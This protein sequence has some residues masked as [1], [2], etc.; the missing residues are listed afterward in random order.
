MRYTQ[1]SLPFSG[2]KEFPK[3]AEKTRYAHSTEHR[4]ELEHTAKVAVSQ[5]ACD[6]SQLSAKHTITFQKL[7]TFQ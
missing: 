4:E 3:I 7:T 5:L 6:S 1:L 2:L